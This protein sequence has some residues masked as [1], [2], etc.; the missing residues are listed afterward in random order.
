MI[1]TRRN[2]YARRIFY[3]R[4]KHRRKVI[5][6][7]GLL[8]MFVADTGAQQRQRLCILK[9]SGMVCGACAAQVEKVAKKIDV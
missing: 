3:E 8:S 5:A 1:S 6:T 2:G 4:A 9:I 7:M